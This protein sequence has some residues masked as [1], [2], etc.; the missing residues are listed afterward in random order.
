M[1]ISDW[2]SDVCSS[3]LTA[4][5]LSYF[6]NNVLH[7]FTASAWIACCF[8]H[9]RRMARRNL[10]EVGRTVYPFLQGELFLPWDQD[11]FPARVD[12]P[13]EVF[14][15]E[16]LLEQGSEQ[17]GGILS[18]HAGP[19]DEVFRLRPVGARQRG[20]QVQ[21]VAGGVARG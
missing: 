18:R 8:Q 7:L 3:D 2:S 5:L 1:R 20:G 17:D 4:V 15:R 12:P 9:N 19:T 13:I 16:G 6:R 14:I 10:L 21:S 11:S